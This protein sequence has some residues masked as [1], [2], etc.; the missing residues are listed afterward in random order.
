MFGDGSLSDDTNEVIFR[1]VHKI[2]Q[3]ANQID[4][5]TSFSY[6]FFISSPLSFV[7]S[8]F[9]LFFCLALIII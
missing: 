2:I 4:A 9:C 6:F 3:Q 1:A 5:K 8:S 7:F